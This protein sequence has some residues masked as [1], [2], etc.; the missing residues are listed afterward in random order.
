MELLDFLNKAADKADAFAREAQE[1]KTEYEDITD[2]ELI[3]EY[4]KIG[5]I[6][7]KLAIVSILEDRGY[8]PKDGK[9]LKL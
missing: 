3:E 9:W 4:Y 8:V 7:K 6:S 2:S 1:H 5:N